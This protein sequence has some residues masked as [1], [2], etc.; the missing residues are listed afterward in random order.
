MPTIGGEPVSQPSEAAPRWLDEQEMAAWLPLV[1]LLNLLPQALDKQLRDD[2]GIGHVYYQILAMLSGAPEQ[3]L[4]MSELA[5]HSA[6]SL[7]RLSHAVSSLEAKGWVE[8]A[9]CA[10][11]KRGQLARLTDGGR[12]MLERTAPGHVDEVR[13][14]VFDRLT[15]REVG[16]LRALAEKVLDG[17]APRSAQLPSRAEETR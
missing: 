4:R 9:A 7:S 13:R 15:R 3:Q 5:R 11:D 10:D 14:L 6:T 16:Q 17:L 2:A 8:R 1:Q 12:R